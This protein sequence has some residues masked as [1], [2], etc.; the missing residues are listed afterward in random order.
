MSNARKSWLQQNIWWK[1]GFQ[2][3]LASKGM[4]SQ[5]GIGDLGESEFPLLMGS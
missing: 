5:S 2:E 1:D 3:V 4:F